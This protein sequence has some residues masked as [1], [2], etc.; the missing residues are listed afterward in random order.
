M[1]ESAQETTLETRVRSMQIIAFSLMA[2]VAFFAAVAVFLQNGDGGEQ[3]E[4][5]PV[6]TFLTYPAVFLA[7]A[8]VVARLMIPRLV[9]SQ[10]LAGLGKPETP[11]HEAGQRVTLL[12]IYQ[13][14]MIVEMA[15]LEGA[16]FFALVAFIVEGR[17]AAFAA[18]AALWVIM[19]LSFPTRSTVEQWVTDQRMEI[20]ARSA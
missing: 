20:D 19:V 7:A 6:A 18:A 4:N 13:T 15:L 8:A 14:R 12:E 16:A 11:V 17:W 1:N 3:L 9:V 2:G 10:R 5:T